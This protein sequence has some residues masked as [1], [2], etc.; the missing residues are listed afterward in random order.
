MTLGLS[1]T[2]STSK[3]E[4]AFRQWFNVP[5]LK[6][7]PALIPFY[8]IT[9]EEDWKSEQVKSLVTDASPITH[10]SKDDP[11]VFMTYGQGEVPVDENSDPGLWVHHARLGLKLK[12]AMGKLGLESHVVWHG[13]PS[14]QYGSIHDF[15]ARKAKGTTEGQY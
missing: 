3:G 1:G 13:N 11:A 6:P 15:L 2:L 8:A 4:L 12:E 14:K 9:S 5:S 10:L 7:Y